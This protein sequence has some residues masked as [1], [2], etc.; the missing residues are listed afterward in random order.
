MKLSLD[1][2][3]STNLIRS[4]G[5]GGVQ[6]GDRTLGHSM[7]VSPTRLI[8]D[9]RPRNFDE[10]L[11]SDLERLL[12][13]RPGVLLIGTGE[14]QRFPGPDLL[15]ALYASRLGFECMDTGAACRTYNV[16]V[17]EGR[18]VAAALIVESH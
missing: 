11:P 4:Y 1:A 9:W 8:E 2:P 16:L 7:I 13:W 18:D 17:A 5:P 3:T 15:A 14:R 12:E 10:F 6:V